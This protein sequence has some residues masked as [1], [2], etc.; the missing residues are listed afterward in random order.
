[1]SK[2]NEISVQLH[3]DSE[4]TAWVK[5]LKQRYLSQRLKAALAASS[6][7]LQYYW[8]LGR[9]IENLQWTNTYGSAF[10]ETLS[11]DLRRE[12][13]DAKGFSVTNLKYMRRFYALY[14]QAIENRPQVADDFAHNRPQVVDD[15]LP[16]N[17]QQAADDFEQAIFSIPWDHHLRIMGKCHG[18]VNKAL[19]FVRKTIENHWGREA[20]LNF[21]DTNLYER[22]GKALTN[23][24]A[25]LPAEQGDLAQQTLHDPYV[26]DF[27]TL[28]EGYDE[29]DLENALVANVTRFLLELGTGFTYAGR[30]MRIDVNGEEFFPDLLFYNTKIH[31]YVVIELK[32][33]HFKPEFLGQLGFYVSAVNHTL[34]S[35]LDNPTIG[36]LICKSKNNVVAQYALEGTTLPLSISEYSLQSLIP[37]NYRTSLP[38][39]EEIESELS[40]ND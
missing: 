15:L 4:Y 3:R 20:L 31:A 27:L 22:E 38:S 35:D 7:M 13:P 26:F 37:E 16:A 18:D 14:S 2:G 39:I 6:E 24:K 28:R 29:R 33:K 34:K 1:M 30:Q 5:N 11:R 12:L 17:R 10:Y 9:D 23:F 8:S 36:L 19:F 25:T 40:K 21:L 32:V